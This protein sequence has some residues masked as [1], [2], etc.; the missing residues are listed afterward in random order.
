VLLLSPKRAHDRAFIAT[1]RPL[2]GAIPIDRMQKAN[3]MVDRDT[4]KSTPAEA[5]RWLVR[6]K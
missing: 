1:L 4:D 6:R 3:L 5:A 2:I